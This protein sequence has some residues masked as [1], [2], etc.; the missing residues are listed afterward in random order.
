[1]SQ[2]MTISKYYNGLRKIH[3][4][5]RREKKKVSNNERKFGIQISHNI[6]T[7]N[8]ETKRKNKEEEKGGKTKSINY[9]FFPLFYARMTYR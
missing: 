7:G 3:E 2:H 5:R 6:T 1:M 8:R 4:K 9:D